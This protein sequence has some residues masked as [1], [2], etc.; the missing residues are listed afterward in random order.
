MVGPTTREERRTASRRFKL[1][2]VVL[3]GLSGGL[4]A[5]QGGGSLF[6]VLLAVLAGLLVG[7]V[8]VVFAFPSGLRED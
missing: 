8:M 7:I 2:F 6:T 5:L 3:V 4:I 1:A